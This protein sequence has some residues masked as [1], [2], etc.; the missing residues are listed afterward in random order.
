MPI[1]SALNAALGNLTHY[2]SKM[3]AWEQKKAAK[4]ENTAQI[5]QKVIVFFSGKGRGGRALIL[6]HLDS[7]MDEVFPHH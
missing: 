6:T 7:P 2:F 4:L 3:Q 1:D 5:S